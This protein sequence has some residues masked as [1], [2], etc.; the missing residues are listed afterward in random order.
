MSSI[1][2]FDIPELSIRAK[3]SC[4]ELACF[5]PMY[6]K[7]GEWVSDAELLKRIERSCAN[8]DALNWHVR[9]VILRSEQDIFNHRSK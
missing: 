2:Y 5:E 9:N 7:D 4:G 8:C 3:F 1:V 6:I